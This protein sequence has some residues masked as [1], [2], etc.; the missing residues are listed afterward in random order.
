MRE[1][2]EDAVRKSIASSHEKHSFF[3]KGGHG[4]REHEQR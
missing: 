4:N 3:F 2:E 1:E